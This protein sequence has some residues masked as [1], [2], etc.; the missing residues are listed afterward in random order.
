MPT[1]RTRRLLFS[2]AAALGVAAGAA[3]IAGAATG[4]SAGS[5][6][7]P[8][9]SA[10]REPAYT[11]SVTAP[12]GSESQSEADETATL[13]GQATVT[14]EQARAAALAAVPGTA[15]EPELENENG[16]VVWGVEITRA[17][18]TVTDV[19]VDAGNAK[20][21]AQ[22]SEDDRDGGAEAHE[23]GEADAEGGGRTSGD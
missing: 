14:S 19:K 10:D 15:A 11:S 8:T 12:E 4:G 16:N 1:S 2:G 23:T 7:P 13:Q 22:E 5:S 20:V 21:L 6:P 9:A 18:G 17:D 3:G